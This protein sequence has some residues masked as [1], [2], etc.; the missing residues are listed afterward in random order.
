MGA[1]ASTG[2]GACAGAGGGAG[3]GAGAGAGARA[4]SCAAGCAVGG[5]D[6]A[7]GTTGA[8][9]VCRGAAGV[10][11]GTSS[12]CR[13]AAGGDVSEDLARGGGD[14]TAGA[15]GAATGA[16]AAGGAAAGTAAA[17]AGAAAAGSSRTDAKMAA[18]PRGSA[19]PVA[20][21][22]VGGDDRKL[23]RSRSDIAV[24]SGRPGGGA[25]VAGSV[26]TAAVPPPPPLALP[27]ELAGRG[28]QPAVARAASTVSCPRCDMITPTTSDSLTSANPARLYR[29]LTSATMAPALPLA[30]VTSRPAGGEGECMCDVA[31]R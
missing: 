20:V 27:L 8:S 18:V 24:P 22:D 1:G 15:G 30:A 26:A 5:G 3:G 7:G 14:A 28:V 13:C 25:I 19:M 31:W 2:T 9:V 12:V 23:P 6:G 17:A 10:G 21:N 4:A 29:S 16:A 11:T